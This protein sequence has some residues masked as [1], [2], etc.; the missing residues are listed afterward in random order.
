MTPLLAILIPYTFD[1]KHLF[2]RLEFELKKQIGDK[3]VVI[4]PNISK[5]HKEGGPSTGRKRNQLVRWAVELDAGYVSHFDS[6]DMPGPNYIKRNFEGIEQ[7]VDC[8]TLLGQ[9]YWSG[10]PGKP[11]YHNINCVNPAT[12]KLE[13]WENDQRYFRTINHLNVQK[14][15]LVKNIPFPDQ[16]FGEDGKQ[17][18]A[19]VKA[20]I[21]KTEYV[22][23]EVIYNYYVGEPKHAL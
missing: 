21:F 1:R 10:K 14:L 6:D 20:G 7:G 13:W 15:S 19:M 17:S 3:P 2:E 23:D 22:I 16:V 8:N 12:G 11:F 18:E 9:I 4:L 5:L